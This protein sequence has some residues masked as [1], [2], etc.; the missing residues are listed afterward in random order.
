VQLLTDV[1][2]VWPDHK[3]GIHTKMLIQLLCEM[4][5]SRW[6]EYNFRAYESEKKRIQPRQLA[7]L[8]RDYKVHPVQV[9]DGK[10]Q[11]G[12]KLKD[13]R[14]AWN[15]Y[16]PPDSAPRTLDPADDGAS[17]DFINPRRESSLDD[18]KMPNPRTDGGSRGLGDKKAPWLKK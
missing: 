9:W 13:L 17:S 7:D 6:I 16:I 8:L 11:N 18:E 4:E 3:D 1:R 10:N 2:E 12:F 14:I 5:E 15:R